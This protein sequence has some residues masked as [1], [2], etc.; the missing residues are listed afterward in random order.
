MLPLGYSG[1][2]QD[3]L[4]ARLDVAYFAHFDVVWMVGELCRQTFTNRFVR[5]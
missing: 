5:F 1:I 2:E 3:E 4:A